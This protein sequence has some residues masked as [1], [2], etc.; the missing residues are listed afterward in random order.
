MKRRVFIFS[1]ISVVGT[2]L[3][4]LPDLKNSNIKMKN[5]LIIQQVQNILFPKN[6][7]ALGAD[8]FGAT[9][10]LIL[11]SKHSSFNKDDL[12][13]L[14]RGSE[15]LINREKK[16]LSLKFQD[17]EKVIKSFSKT[18]FGENWLSLLLFYTIEALVS[19]PI[20]GGNKSESG[21]KWLGHNAGKPRPKLKYVE[22]T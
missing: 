12:K 4:I 3:D 5:W 7:N 17:Q 9:N 20:Y 11:V 6:N 14:I 19:D 22:L 13:F 16:F 8:E 18:R 10:Y 1:S 15:E 21:W 2:A